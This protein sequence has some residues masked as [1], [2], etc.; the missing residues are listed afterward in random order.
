MAASVLCTYKHS[1]NVLPRSQWSQQCLLGRCL[2]LPIINTQHFVSL[3]K[4]ECINQS[5]NQSFILTCCVEELKNWFKIRKSL[6]K[7]YNN[8][9][10]VLILFYFKNNTINICKL[11]NKNIKYKKLKPTKKQYAKNKTGKLRMYKQDSMCRM[12]GTSMN[13]SHWGMKCSL[14]EQIF[15]SNHLICVIHLCWFP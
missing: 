1:Q 14:N 11:S 13:I 5:I 4:H 6:N 10:Y 9:S 8:Y 15:R 7:I 3:A 2:N 12:S